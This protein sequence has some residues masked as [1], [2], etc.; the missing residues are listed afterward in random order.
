MLHVWESGGTAFLVLDPEAGGDTY[1][2]DRAITAII[3]GGWFGM[4][5]GVNGGAKSGQW[6]AQ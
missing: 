5:P 2:I 4:G 3:E 6:A 1:Q